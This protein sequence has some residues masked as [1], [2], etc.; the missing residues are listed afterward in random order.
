LAAALGAEVAVLTTGPAGGLEFEVAS[1]ALAA[2]VAP[3]RERAAALG[4]RLALEP[5]NQLRD[6]LGFVHTLRDTVAV[7]DATGIGVC[8]DLLWCWRE[9]A[10]RETLAAA[11]ERIELVQVSDCKVGMTS[12]PCRVVPAD[13]AIPLVRVLGWIVEAGY[14]GVFELE[15]VGP[16]IDAEGPA[17]ALRRAAAWL[18]AALA[19]LGT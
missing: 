19:R 17:D 16:E 12:M 3:L 18:S 1:D 4:L 14:E 2:A 15:L 10:L 7:A 8:V 13:G 11:A 6:D 5:T 9:P